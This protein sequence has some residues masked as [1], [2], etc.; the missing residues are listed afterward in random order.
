MKAFKT[1]FSAAC[2][3][4]IDAWKRTVPWE[5]DGGVTGIP[6]FIAAGA[7]TPTAFPTP[8][9]KPL[10]D[11]IPPIT[12]L[13]TEGEGDPDENSGG[14]CGVGGGGG[15]DKLFAAVGNALAGF[16]GG[17]E[18]TA[19]GVGFPEATGIVT[20]GAGVLAPTTVC[21]SPLS[22]LP[23]GGNAGFSGPVVTVDGVTVVVVFCDDVTADADGIAAD[24][25]AAAGEELGA[26][27]CSCP[28]WGEGATGTDVDV[29]VE[30]EPW[31]VVALEA[32]AFA[33]T[34]ADSADAGGGGG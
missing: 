24:E 11:D 9:E 33:V 16:A 18:S 6:A 22:L 31:D 19:L 32:D 34:A 8:G 25:E 7:I 10:G 27:W 20:T 26:A 15:D 28:C 2:H 12:G 4:L 17:E 30:A 13:A 21:V 29:G 14:G 23:V 1:R 5:V 3:C